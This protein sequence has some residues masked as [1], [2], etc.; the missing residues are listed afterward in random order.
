[1]DESPNVRRAARRTSYNTTSTHIPGFQM[2][3]ALSSIEH[4]E[5]R[6]L[7]SSVSLGDEGGGGLVRYG[8]EEKSDG[9]LYDILSRVPSVT[10]SINSSMASNNAFSANREVHRSL[11]SV[12]GYSDD[13]FE[14]SEDSKRAE[15]A[16]ATDYKELEDRRY[17]KCYCHSLSSK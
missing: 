11:K 4:G 1:M 15:P 8:S 9:E 12:E 6:E 13:D 10:G 17:Q 7:P 16:A 3:T 14:A 5:R 2:S